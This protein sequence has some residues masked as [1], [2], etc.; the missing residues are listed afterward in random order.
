[1]G[2]DECQAVICDRMRAASV[3]DC[4]EIWYDVQSGAG[5][6]RR[7]KMLS[8]SLGVTRMDD[9]YRPS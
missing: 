8:F 2:G 5:D 4:I 3:K 6:V 1:M 9:G 7:L